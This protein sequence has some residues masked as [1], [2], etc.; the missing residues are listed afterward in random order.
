M[1]VIRIVEADIN[2]V[3]S[4]RVGRARGSVDPILSNF[5][6]WRS[7]A[8]GVLIGLEPGPTPTWLD[9]FTAGLHR[10]APFQAVL[11][12]QIHTNDRNDAIGIAR[13][14]DRWFKEVHVKDIDSPSLKRSASRALLVKIKR[15]LDKPCRGPLIGGR[16]RHFAGGLLAICGCSLRAVSAFLP[17]CR[18]LRGFDVAE[19]GLELAVRC[20]CLG[21]HNVHA[22]AGPI[23]DALKR[24]LV[25]AYGDASCTVAECL[26]SWRESTPFPTYNC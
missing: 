14:S 3:G 20:P 19:F 10:R 6:L 15:D 26:E 8:G 25:A 24:I 9:G 13:S 22:I 1:S 23:T 7:S 2:R 17:C 11:K 12:M 18:W 5:N 16:R 4:S 21:W